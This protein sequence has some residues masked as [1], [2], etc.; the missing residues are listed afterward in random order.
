VNDVLTLTQRVTATAAIAILV[1][2]STAGPA[3]G[4]LDANDAAVFHASSSDAYRG[5]WRMAADGDLSDLWK[6]ID[7]LPASSDDAAALKSTLSA[8]KTH[9]T[10]RNAQTQK[11]HEEAVAEMQKHLDAG[12]M[13]KA[14][15]S[16][17][18]AHGLAPD[19]KAFLKDPRVVDLAQRAEA[20][21]SLAEKRDAWFEALLLYRRLDYLFD[22]KDRYRDPMRRVSRKLALLRLYA[23]D[24]YYDRA[25]NYARTQ[26]EEPAGR[27]EGEEDQGW[28]AELAGIDETM[29]LQAMTR[30]ADK[31]V[32]SSNYEK[33]FIGGLESLRVLLATP[34]L[35]DTFKSL[36]DKQQVER[37]DAYIAAVIETLERQNNWMTYSQASTRIKN[38]LEKNR[39]SVNLPE[40]VLIHEFADGAM[41]TLDDFTGII[42]PTEMERF[43]RT[44]EQQFS[45]VGIQITLSDDQ[46]TVVSPLEGT[47]AHRAG[48]KAGDRI[49]TIDGKATTGIS[50]EQAVR[51]ITGK[52]GTKV[53][54]GIKRSEADAAKVV[55]LKRS[56]IQI[57]SVR[58]FQRKPGGEWEYFVDPDQ[59]I[60]YI[61]I[62]QF[63]PDTVTE[64]DKAVDA[65]KA[66]GPIHGLILDLRF[67]PGGLLK[68]AV[69]VSNRFI[70]EGVIV[71]GQTQGVGERW[72]AKAD[73]KDTYPNFPVVVLINKGSA[74]AS[75][76]VSGALQDHHRALIVGENSYGKGSV[77]QLFG[78]KW[79]SAY[80]KVTT[81][82]YELPSG[83]IIHRRPD[84]TLWGVKPDVEVKM[85]D[86]QV[87]K[88]I[89]ARMVVDVLR[90]PDEQVDPE[91]LIGHTDEE[92]GQT[93]EEL[94]R[95]A[96]EIL[97][98]GIDPQLETS[99]LLLQA[100]LVNDLAVAE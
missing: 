94:P 93:L 28:E 41:S 16:A 42:W 74:S 7:A 67:N 63:G 13:S 91:S 64:M 33:L 49:V 21:A 56:K 25:D 65:M 6:S 39:E 99:V 30:A 20:A 84:A 2:C 45:G 40:A 8:Y 9:E 4:Q 12:E 62:T 87:E 3:A 10:Q 46:L 79:N 5:A 34:G 38:L 60:G 80:V 53:K 22:E 61:R 54:L 71:G 81:Q 47:P 76:I 100:R 92:E 23:P 27:W 18:E 17:N 89:K 15:A 11:A 43:K 19:P 68:A 70:D 32:E 75:E 66:T 44:T 31:H 24:A 14:L 1:A 78:L 88:L 97:E 83:R 29:L 95:S 86:L 72:T 85:T 48:L 77:Q 82:Y 50:L 26:G 37:F 96:M 90:N 58:G 98:R 55:T 35:S 51:A 73:A 69:D 36:E 57:D 59:R 52:E